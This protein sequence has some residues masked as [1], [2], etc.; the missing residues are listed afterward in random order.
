MLYF[1]SSNNSIWKETTP[2]LNVNIIQSQKRK[3]TQFERKIENKQ[4]IE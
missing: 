4:F 3:F 1:A 2:L